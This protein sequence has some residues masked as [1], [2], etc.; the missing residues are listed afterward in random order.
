MFYAL[1]ITVCLAMLFLAMAGTVLLWLPLCRLLSSLIERIANSAKPRTAANFLFIVRSL[2]L[3]LAAAVTV[4]FALPA[5]LEF[6]PRTTGEA[7][8]TKLAL[9]SAAGAFI[10][11][12]MAVRGLRVLRATTRTE[13]SWRERSSSDA[14]HITGSRVPLYFV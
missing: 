9:L 14:A 4:G 13:K 7:M 1:G 11:A 6:E 5:F 10:L 3:F 8:S 12:A 2:P